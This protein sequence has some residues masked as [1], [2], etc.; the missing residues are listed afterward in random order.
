MTDQP[1]SINMS[2][3]S[4]EV[5]RR[6][7]KLDT[8]RFECTQCEKL[9]QALTTRHTLFGTLEIVQK[10]EGICDQCL[11]KRIEGT[12]EALEYFKEHPEQLEEL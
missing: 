1:T 2:A 5:R 11:K 4:K 8:H 10:G 6:S 9:S 7:H 12:I 3:V